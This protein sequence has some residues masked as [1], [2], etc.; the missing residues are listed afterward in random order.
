MPATKRP[1]STEPTASPACSDGRSGGTQCKITR[2]YKKAVPEV[3]ESDVGSDAGS[4]AGSVAQSQDPYDTHDDLG[5]CSEETNPG[6][7]VDQATEKAERGEWEEGDALPKY[8][9]K[10][11]EKA[12][13]K[14]KYH[15][16]AY[17][18]GKHFNERDD[19]PN[20][21][22]RKLQA[23]HADLDR[24][25]MPPT[26]KIAPRKR[27]EKQSEV[28]GVLWSPQDRKWKGQL[29]D[30]VES[31]KL[32]STVSVLAKRFD[33][34]KGKS[35]GKSG[36]WTTQFDDREECEQATIALR[37]E[38]EAAFEAWIA[39]Q[40]AADP[41][42]RGLPRAPADKKDCKKGVVYCVANKN[43]KWKP[44][45]MAKFGTQ[46]HRACNECNQVAF[47][48]GKGGEATRCIVHGGGPR[49]ESGVHVLDDVAPWAGYVVSDMAVSKDSN[50]K[51]HPRPKWAGKRFCMGC[52]KYFDPYNEV[53]KAFVHKEDLVLSGVVEELYKRGL[54]DLASISDGILKNDC[55]EGESRR[56]KDLNVD[57]D[58]RLMFMV[59]NDENQHRDRTTSCERKKLAGH[60]VDAGATGF[61]KQED[62]LWAAS[63]PTDEQ[64][65]AIRETDKDTPKMQR[66]RRARK[67]ANQRLV[68]EA[69]AKARAARS[70]GAGGAA[71]AS[72][73]AVVAPKLH[74]LRFNCDE[75]VAKDGTEEGTRVGSLF[76]T[77]GNQEKGETLKLKP[78]RLFKKAIVM[79]TDRILEIIELSKDDA[80]I[81]AHKEWHVE[82]MRYDGCDVDGLDRDGSVEATQASKKVEKE[83]E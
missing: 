67:K 2:F 3:A 47:G 58:P 33:E 6:S 38:L 31:A 28:D 45:R 46:C 60:L 1:R 73:D 34:S 56:R 74:C 8:V 16:K 41:L 70:S 63:L 7:E 18:G 78:T 35:V 14:K 29:H 76:R 55:Q 64:L 15:L 49:C 5:G 26:R 10:V 37:A 32:G 11:S 80:W 61:S 59:E 81:E 21:L 44:I 75:F 54:G 43:D 20:V 42:V 19:D 65:E 39:A 48:D 68:R 79:L 53:V 24:Q 72:A 25:G 12:K 50:G 27:A 51:S 71:G 40:Q 82:Y 62:E 69:N 9:Y 30:R 52:M 13:H 36:R 77:T 17:R 23:W 57:T 66:L 22:Y 4:D 83:D